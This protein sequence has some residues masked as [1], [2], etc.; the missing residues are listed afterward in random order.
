MIKKS[1]PLSMVEATKYLG[2]DKENI[3]G[4]IGKFNKLKSKE[5]EEFRKKLRELNLMKVNDNQISK[6]IDII[7]ATTEEVHKIFTDI[8]LNEDETKKIIDVVKQF[9]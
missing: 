1:T 7:P 3:K 2:K 5:G 4:F 9:K 8:S 6:V